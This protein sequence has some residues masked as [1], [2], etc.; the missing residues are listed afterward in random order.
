MGDLLVDLG[1]VK[2]HKFTYVCEIDWT[3]M[4]VSVRLQQRPRP[5]FLQSGNSN[6]LVG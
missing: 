3:A 4:K 2:A 1:S 5:A 6:A